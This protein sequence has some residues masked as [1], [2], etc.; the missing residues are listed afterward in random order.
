MSEFSCPACPWILGALV[1]LVF[2]GVLWRNH[3]SRITRVDLSSRWHPPEDEQ[4]RARRSG[5]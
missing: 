5:L 4:E 1:V 3:R 2:A